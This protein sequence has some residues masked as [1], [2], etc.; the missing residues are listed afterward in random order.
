MANTHLNYDYSTPD[1]TPAYPLEFVAFAVG[2]NWALP[3]AFEELRFWLTTASGISR[4][5]FT[6]M[7]PLAGRLI[8]DN[9]LDADA[10]GDWD[11]DGVPNVT[12]GNV[13]YKPGI[14]LITRPTDFD[15]LTYTLDNCP[16]LPNLSQADADGDGIGDDCDNCVN[17]A[18]YP[19]EDWDQDGFGSACDPDV[20][21]D[22][23]IQAEVDLAVVRQCQGE[24][25][26]C[27]AHLTFPDIPPG[28]SAP[29]LNG[30]AVLIADMD[31][32]EDV[33]ANDLAAWERLAADAS[34]RV[35]GFS[36]AGSAPCPDPS[37]VMLRNGE[38]VT[39]PDTA[40]YPHTC[41]L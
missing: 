30:Q 33:D 16:Y 9:V 36:C 23:L 11:N 34:L 13:M 17:I 15:A 8:L 28:Q 7:Q 19:Q 40:P 26:D 20:N 38:T 41:T 22:G 24:P 35:S 14:G 21:N 10:D 32:D 29:D 5:W 12:F 27:L 6:P 4:Y 18:N 3:A 31:A 2:P 1:G 37:I 39:I 25:I